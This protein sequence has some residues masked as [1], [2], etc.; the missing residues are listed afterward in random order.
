M[1]Q[2]LLILILVFLLGFVAVQLFA[3]KSQYAIETHKYHVENK[4]D[5]IE[6]SNEN[7]N[8]TNSQKKINLI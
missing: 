6:I 7:P 1:R 4:F 3:L 5:D 8:K 2:I